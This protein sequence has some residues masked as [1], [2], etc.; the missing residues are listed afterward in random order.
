MCCFEIVA[1]LIV[2]GLRFGSELFFTH[3]TNFV[4]FDIRSF[5]N[6]P[7]CLFVSCDRDLVVAVAIATAVGVGIVVCHE[8]AL[9]ALVFLVADD[10][11]A[12]TVPLAERLVPYGV[13]PGREPGDDD[14]AFFMVVQP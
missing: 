6:E 3:L 9:V 8:L 14:P 13:V 11:L 2:G 12:G 10:V 5:E 7:E 1:H 4:D